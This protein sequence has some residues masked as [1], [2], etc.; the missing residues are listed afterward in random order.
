MQVWDL[1]GT[2]ELKGVDKVLSGINNVSKS[3][4]NV[5][6]KITDVGKTLTMSISAPLVAIGLKSVKLASDLEEANNVVTSTFKEQGKS[7]IDWSK[8]LKD[9][10]GLVQLEASKWVGS[11]GA[12]LT[13]SGL[14]SKASEDM[15]KKLVEL[16]GD[17][18]S[19]YNLDHEETWEKIR[20]GISGE[21]EPLK[22][23]GI[24]MSVAN[25]EAFALSKGINKAWNEMSQAEQVTLRYNYLLEQT[26]TAQGDFERTSEGLSNQL[27][28]LEGNLTNIQLNIGNALLPFVNTVV[29]KFA[30]WADK[31]SQMNTQDQALL[32]FLGALGVIIPPLIITFGLLV[33]AI[34]MLLTPIGLA[35]GA[36]GALTGGFIASQIQSQGLEG[37]I[38]SLKNKMIE[39]KGFVMDTLVPALQ[40]LA[41][42]EGLEK[43]Q[44]SSGITRDKLEELRTKFI[45]V[46]DKVMD[47]WDWL[48]KIKDIMA[49]K[50]PPVI[51]ELKGLW[52]ELKISASY[53]KQAIDSLA[54]ASGT[55]DNNISALVDG[56][57]ELIKGFK[58]AIGWA[59]DLVGALQSVQRWGDKASKWWADHTGISAIQNFGDKLLGFAGGTNYAPG[60]WSLVG[61]EGAELVNL[62]RGSRVFNARQTASMLSGGG[63]N[64]VNTSVMNNYITVRMDDLKDI[65]TWNDFSKRLNLEAVARGGY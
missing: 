49:E 40:Y 36:I 43:V 51:E 24:N 52:D 45:E 8:T 25:L 9:K 44:N 2:L 61:E 41:T 26:T 50:L 63:G 65:M 33:T 42:G 35:V 21:T 13:S 62:P 17:M 38:G 46:K 34:G 31:L 20:S 48:M 29:T 10:Y 59:N 15:S 1:Y 28:I 12:M 4:V 53:L 58:T 7:V 57:K 6:K 64:S 5:G 19:F 32:L 16:T 47:F 56:V 54:G 18:S 30:E 60:G 39:L 37:F 3:F 14:S 27:R 11:M 22:I 23:L 55:A